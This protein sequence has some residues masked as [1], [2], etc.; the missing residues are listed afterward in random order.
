MCDS[1]FPLKEMSCLVR[2]RKSQPSSHEL[3]T[4]H[5]NRP[6]SFSTKGIG[7]NV[8]FMHFISEVQS[9]DVTA[10]FTIARIRKFQKSIIRS[11]L[12]LFSSK[13]MVS[14]SQKISVQH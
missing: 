9:S 6:F 10:S 4:I 2:N 8:I 1:T 12:S 14:L 7:S 3:N 11:I 13:L 5:P